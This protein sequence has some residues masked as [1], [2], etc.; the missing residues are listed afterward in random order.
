MRTSLNG[1]Q[2]LACML[3]VSACRGHTR[4]HIRGHG[5]L[6]VRCAE[7]RPAV[8]SWGLSS[9]PDQRSLLQLGAHQGKKRPIREDPQRAG[10]GL[11]RPHQTTSQ[12]RGHDQG[13]ASFRDII[14]FVQWFIL[15]NVLLLSILKQLF[16]KDK[17]YS[18]FLLLIFQLQRPVSYLLI[19]SFIDSFLNSNS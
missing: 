16:L 4:G 17:C 12:V 8:V 3:C 9:G 13:L 10:R 7:G 1:L 5:V 19:S 2:N 6:R 11:G 18:H 14:M 15:S